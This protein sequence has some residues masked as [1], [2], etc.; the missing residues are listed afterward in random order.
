MASAFIAQIIGF[1]FVML[2]V[3]LIITLPIILFY[4]LIKF[5]NIKKNI[6]DKLKG[7]IKQ[8]GEKNR[9]IKGEGRNIEETSRDR[10]TGERRGTGEGRG[11]ISS[12]GG[13]EEEIQR[14]WRV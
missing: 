13:Y 9:F 10:G 11:W 8:N 3:V 4:W 12:N 1:F 5:K 7:G 14:R 6:P 2:V